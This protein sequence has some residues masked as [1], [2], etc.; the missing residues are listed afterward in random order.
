MT[1]GARKA[2]MAAGVAAA[3]VAILLLSA[4]VVHPNKSPGWEQDIF[5]AINGLPQIL[6]WPVWVIMQLGNLLVIPV[7]VLGA[8]VWRKWRLAAALLV[9]G[10][11]KIQLGT[12]IKDQWTRE[13]PASVI[14]D[15]IRRGDASP[16]GEAFV[17]GHAIIAGALAVL[18]TPYLP[19][20]W[21]I[22]VWALAAGVCLGRVY[23]G[24]HLPLDVLAGAAVGAAVGIVLKW[25]LGLRG[26]HAG[27]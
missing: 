21:R 3:C 27:R 15:V 23:V 26:S 16:S 12:V 4:S 25:L 9:A 10:V 19:R 22:V 5:H 2:L 18:L 8:A 7:A 24:A 6:Y 20:K 14:E 17:S 13:R 1:A 11:A